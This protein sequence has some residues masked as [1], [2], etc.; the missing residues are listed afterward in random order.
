MALT[1]MG[2]HW[3]PNGY[4]V[5]DHGSLP[6]L[7]FEGRH[8]VPNCWVET[9][10]IIV[11]EAMNAVKRFTRRISNEMKFVR[12]HLEEACVLLRVAVSQASLFLQTKKWKNVMVL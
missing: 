3:G 12:E 2:S 5:I 10:A 1:L 6:G 4:E 8:G 11:L 9:L 7:Y